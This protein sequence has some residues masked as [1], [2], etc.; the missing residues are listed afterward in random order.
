[1]EK[2]FKDS[3][4]KYL[5]FVTAYGKAAD[6][7]LYEDEDY[8]VAFDAEKGL[9]LYVKG[10]LKIMHGVGEL[11]VPIGTYDG[12]LITVS[13]SVSQETLTLS[14]TVWNFASDEE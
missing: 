2:H 7:L 9:D 4:E 12:G 5:N 13:A 14:G 6:G 11:S 3:E 1:M 8:T 10:L